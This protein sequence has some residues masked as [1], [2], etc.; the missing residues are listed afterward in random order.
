MCFS[1]HWLVCVSQRQVRVNTCCSAPQL[2]TLHITT[3]RMKIFSFSLPQFNIYILKW[4]LPAEDI[5]MSLSRSTEAH[6]TLHICGGCRFRFGSCL[7]SWS[8]SLSMVI[9][10][11]CTV[12]KERERER[13]EKIWLFWLNV[14]F[15][16]GLLMCVGSN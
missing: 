8:Y 1:W 13:K 10:L 7:M 12:L 15:T 9:C 16:E 2:H 5:R 11:Y 4:K 6:D 3:A 14:T